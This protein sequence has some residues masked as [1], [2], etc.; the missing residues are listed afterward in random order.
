M[1]KMKNNPFKRERREE[2]ERQRKAY[3]L[4]KEQRE[5]ARAA[6]DSLLKFLA[7]GNEPQPRDFGPLPFE[8]DYDEPQQQYQPQ[9]AQP[10]KPYVKRG[11]W[12][13]DGRPQKPQ[14]SDPNG[15]R[16]T[17]TPQ[18]SRKELRDPYARPEQRTA[19]KLP[20][21]EDNPKTFSQLC[22]GDVFWGISRLTRKPVKAYVFDEHYMVNGSDM[23]GMTFHSAYSQT[24]YSFSL[25]SREDIAVFEGKDC[26]DLFGPDADFILTT[27]KPKGIPVNGC[28]I[29]ISRKDGK[30]YEV[31]SVDAKRKDW[32]PEARYYV[33]GNDEHV[34]YRAVDRKQD[35]KV[36]IRFPE[37]FYD[38]FKRIL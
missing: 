35:G 29:Y 2:G 21:F 8:E 37:D 15:Y 3:E 31:L 19:P 6:N 22:S 34:V 26:I 4:S 33:W 1:V 30:T 38:N 13:P 17:F 14:K 12:N 23:P 16:R 27:R 9:H 25:R 20:H 10:R 32:N 11:N 5:T 24:T 36:E 7:G 18:L 28:G